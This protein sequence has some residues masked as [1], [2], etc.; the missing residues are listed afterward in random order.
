MHNSSFPSFSCKPPGFCLKRGCCPFSS[1][2]NSC[3][4]AMRL[5][6]RAS[7]G[8][9][10]LQHPLLAPDEI[11]RSCDAILHVLRRLLPQPWHS[12]CHFVFRSSFKQQ[13]GSAVR[14]PVAHATWV[15]F[16]IR[17]EVPYSF[18][19]CM[20]LDFLSTDRMIFRPQPTTPMYTDTEICA[21]RA[22]QRSPVNDD[23]HNH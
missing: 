1:W 23:D 16:S 8:W 17:P 13:R 15:R 12:Y 11:L 14:H 5:Y 19:F 21:K 20:F 4:I 9:G 6:M 10:T 18:F 3:A 7:N 22:V 2:S